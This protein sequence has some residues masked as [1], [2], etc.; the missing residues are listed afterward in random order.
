MEEAPVPPAVPDRKPCGTFKPPI[1]YQKLM[2]DNLTVIRPPIL[3]IFY[4]E[5]FDI[6]G[7]TVIP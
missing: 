7:S 1:V 2:V 3:K 6:T 5:S 4:W